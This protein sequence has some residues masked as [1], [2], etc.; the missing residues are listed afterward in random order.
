M[1]QLLG[2]GLGVTL[3][4]NMKKTSADHVLTIYLKRS[5]SAE[6][7]RGEL[8]SVQ[9]GP[10]DWKLPTLENSG[11]IVPDPSKFTLPACKG[12]LETSRTEGTEGFWSSEISGR[13]GSNAAA[14]AGAK[15][16]AGLLPRTD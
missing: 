12:G 1:R 11:Q 3:F 6:P 9:S 15:R 5:H 13:L 10:F 16:A 4:G 2:D 7:P 14:E 8:P